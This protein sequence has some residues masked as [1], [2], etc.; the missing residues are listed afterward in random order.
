MYRLAEGGGTPTLTS[1]PSTSSGLTQM[2][3]YVAG[4][5]GPRGNRSPAIQYVESR[6]KSHLGYVAGAARDGLTYNRSTPQPSMPSGAGSS[7][8]GRARL[9]SF[10]APRTLYEGPAPR[11][12]V[13]VNERLLGGSP[14]SGPPQPPPPPPPPPL[15]NQAALDHWSSSSSSSSS[16]SSSRSA[17]PVQFAPATFINRSTGQ[18]HNAFIRKS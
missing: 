18:S 10:D 6:P 12:P 17:S 7:S 9:N 8:T 13:L 14:H 11:E 2:F 3:G 1:R 15:L 16:A 4:A 5:P